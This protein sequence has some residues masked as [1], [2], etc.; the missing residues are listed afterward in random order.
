MTA[1]YNDKVARHVELDA[2]FDSPE[3]KAAER[4]VA[5]WKLRGEFI[6]ALAVYFTGESPITDSTA[7]ALRSTLLDTDEATS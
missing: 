4:E 7:W 1:D 3:F 5:L 2:L 6:D